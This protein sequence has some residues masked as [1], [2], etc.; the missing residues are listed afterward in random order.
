MVTD[1]V[2][3]VKSAVP[4]QDQSTAR[5]FCAPG[6]VNL[7]GEHTDYN[8]GFVMPAAIDFATWVVAIPHDGRILTVFSEN[9]SET[10]EFDLDDPSQA[11]QGHCR[12]A[13][14]NYGSVYCRLRRERESFVA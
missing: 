11:A 14:R 12:H 10:I 13:L 4:D 6:R 7:I 8:D 9:F 1:Q 2:T 3:Q 5:L